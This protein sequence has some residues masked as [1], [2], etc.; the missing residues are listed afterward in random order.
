MKTRQ[1]HNRK[2]SFPIQREGSNTGILPL[3]PIPNPLTSE[4]PSFFSS[5]AFVAGSFPNENPFFSVPVPVPVALLVPPKPPNAKPFFSPS[6]ASGAGVPVGVNPPN[7]K[8]L[9]TGAGVVLVLS[10]ETDVAAVE[11]PDTPPRENPFPRFRPRDGVVVLARGVVPVVV[12]GSAGLGVVLTLAGAEEK[13][14]EGFSVG[15]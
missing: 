11:V 8:S 3:S 15:F 10:P 14:K 7:P 12:L 5:V 1:Q 2:L 9:F 6:F 4:V 13:L